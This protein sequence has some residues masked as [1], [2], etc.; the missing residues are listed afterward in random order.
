MNSV[1]SVLLFFVFLSGTAFS[2]EALPDLS[3]EAKI[4]SFP[5]ADS[6]PKTLGGLRKDQNEIAIT[7]DDGPTPSTT[8]K[9]LKIFRDYKIKATFFLVGENAKKYP[10]MVK[11]ILREGHSIANH[12]WSHPQ[13]MALSSA[14]AA[15]EIDRS[16]QVLNEIVEDMQRH[17]ET[18]NAVVQPF[19]RFPYGDGASDE[20][21]I[22]LLRERGLANFYWRMSA[23]DSRTQDPAVALKTSIEM[24]DKYRSGIFLMHETHPAGL[25]M[26]PQFLGELRRRHYKTYYFQI[27]R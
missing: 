4:I 11:A 24:L 13:M 7:V 16:A 9:I 18:E 1:F 12:T 6:S 26:L 3:S 25:G 14:E 17:G 23:H 2:A 20:K 8:P 15:S 19:F 10:E 22:Q 27:Q 21:L 5:I